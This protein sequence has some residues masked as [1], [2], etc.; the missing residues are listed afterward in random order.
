MERKIIIMKSIKVNV[1]RVFL[2]VL[3]ILMFGEK[4]NANEAKKYNDIFLTNS[5][6]NNSVYIS[7]KINKFAL[8]HYNELSD[9]A[10]EYMGEKSNVGEKLYIGEPF[11]VI[12]V[13][14]INQQ[15]VVYYPIMDTNK[16]YKL[17]MEVVCINNCCGQAFL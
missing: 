10:M 7:D 14:E 5:I 11:C 16:K 8:E 15:S 13:D 3:V 9:Y 12:N 4:V 1:S 6:E 17:L 2:V